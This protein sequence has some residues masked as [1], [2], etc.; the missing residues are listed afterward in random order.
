M[1]ALDVAD[2]LERGKQSLCQAKPRARRGTLGASVFAGELDA[3]A[4]I[5]RRGLSLRVL[6]THPL[7][8]QHAVETCEAKPTLRGRLP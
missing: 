7:Y 8:A 3:L 2:S 1:R 5:S 6:T 4:L